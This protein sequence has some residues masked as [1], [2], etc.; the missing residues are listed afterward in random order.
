MTLLLI[1]IVYLFLFGLKKR[2]KILGVEIEFNY[3][4][5]LRNE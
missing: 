5:L 1:I 2:I 4:G 3:P